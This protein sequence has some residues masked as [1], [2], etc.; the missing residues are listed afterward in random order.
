MAKI[1][2]TPDQERELKKTGY[3]VKP[4]YDAVNV[5]RHF[6]D[7]HKDE[8]GNVMG[9]TRPLPADARRLNNYLRYGFRLQDPEGNMAPPPGYFRKRMAAMPSPGI[10]QASNVSS[11]EIVKKPVKEGV[12][13]AFECGI[14]HQWF[15]D[16]DS[17]IHHMIYHR[18]AK[19]KAEAK[20]E[21][22]EITVKA[23]ACKTKRGRAIS[24]ENTSA[25][26]AE[27]K[28]EI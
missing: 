4:V 14:C 11:G 24:S 5:R 1:E 7:P 19:A 27:K 18:S 2:V 26:S 6:W 15:P 16:T 13:G 25:I 20:K 10:A 17:L 22:V 23:K 9:W 28:E 3:V 8:K 21:K 12:P